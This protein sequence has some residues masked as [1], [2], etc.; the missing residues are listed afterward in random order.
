MNPPSV[1]TSRIRGRVLRADTGS[2]L[3]RAFV[4]LQT[5]EGRSVESVTTDTTGAYEFSDMAPGA[6]AVKAHK[7]GFLSRWHGAGRSDGIGTMVKVGRAQVVERADITLPPG[8][9][10]AGRVLDA[11]GEP[12][13]DALV[14]VG[15]RYVV[16]T[17]PHAS[18]ASTEPSLT[19]SA[20]TAC[21]AFRP[22]STTSWWNRSIFQ[23]ASMT[24]LSCTRRPGTLA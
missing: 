18:R 13:L 20:G 4:L 22:G 12:V 11:S 16:P 23:P 17:A 7:D 6:Y 5:P 9:A 3:R 1:G 19:T 14:S 15:V 24:G 21:G 8:C 2:P 10:V